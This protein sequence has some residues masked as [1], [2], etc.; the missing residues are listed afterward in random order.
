M[1]NDPRL[2]TSV[3]GNKNYFPYFKRTQRQFRNPVRHTIWTPFVK[4]GSIAFKFLLL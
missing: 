2:E 1:Y 3:E 4:K